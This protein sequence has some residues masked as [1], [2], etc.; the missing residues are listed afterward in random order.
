MTAAA[1]RGGGGVAMAAAALGGGGCP[2]RQREQPSAVAAALGDGDGVE[3]ILLPKTAA[4]E[5][6][7]SWYGA[8]PTT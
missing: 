2:W 3:E 8:P 1:A 7:N 4:W 5:E 6:E